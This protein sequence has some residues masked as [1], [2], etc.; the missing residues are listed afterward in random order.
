M[1][2]LRTGSGGAVAKKQWYGTFGKFST[3]V[4]G[5]PTWPTLHAL[6]RRAG[7][8]QVE[9]RNSQSLLHLLS[10]S[11]GKRGWCVRFWHHG[12]SCGHFFGTWHAHRIITCTRVTL[13][14]YHCHATSTSSITSSP[15]TLSVQPPTHPHSLTHVCVVK[16]IAV[17]SCSVYLVFSPEILT[18]NFS[19][20]WRKHQLASLLRAW[21]IGRDPAPVV[22][23]MSLTKCTCFLFKL[24]FIVLSLLF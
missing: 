4:I 18:V 24:V 12:T 3:F 13:F 15:P 19:G 1:S 6:I 20:S 2:V 9:V 23:W 16:G 21:V 11:W 17:P 8:D 7:D 22:R 14:S 10:Q 5:S